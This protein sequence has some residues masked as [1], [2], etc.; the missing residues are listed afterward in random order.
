M[1]LFDVLSK[2]Q[3]EA[4]ILKKM[5]FSARCLGDRDHINRIYLAVRAQHGNTHFSIQATT[6]GYV[7]EPHSS[8]GHTMWEFFW[9][10][11]YF[12]DRDL[13]VMTKLQFA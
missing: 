1:A 3:V 4:A 7:V 2:D 6:N 5:P 8:P 9:D 11:F 10:S 13:A 12:A